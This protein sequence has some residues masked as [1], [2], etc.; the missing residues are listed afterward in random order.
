VEE[1][2]QKK[3]ML[4]EA[5]SVN[6]KKKMMMMIQKSGHCVHHPAKNHLYTNVMKDLNNQPNLQ[7]I[8]RKLGKAQTVH[9]HLFFAFH[10]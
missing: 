4:R 9:R 6:K 8:K 5:N 10:I 3:M 7:R 2:F 1:A